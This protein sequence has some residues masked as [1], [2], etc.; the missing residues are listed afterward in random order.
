MQ[1]RDK[2]G[3]VRLVAMD[4]DGVLTDGSLFYSSKGEEIKVFHVRDGMGITLAHLAGLEVA[5]IT[6]RRT[7]A[8]E[9]RARELKVR[10]LRMG[11]PDKV[12]ALRE[13]SEGLEIRPAEIAFIGDDLNDLAAFGYVGMAVT[14][15]GAPT[16]LAE[17]ADYTTRSPGG[18][19]AVR[20]VI[21]MVLKL[22]GRWEGVVA[23]VR[24]N[25]GQ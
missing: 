20:E 12:A 5:I 14:V 15:P 2:A 6:G 19:G 8:L 25:S 24:G 9:A 22:Q 17:A 23:A 11:V 13:I 7:E 21:E 3:R 10:H 1:L 18:R 16:E 4:V